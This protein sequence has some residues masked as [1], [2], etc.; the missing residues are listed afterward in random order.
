MKKC[1]STAGLALL[2]ALVMSVVGV[3]SASALE[4]LANGSA[5]TTAVKT[6][7]SGT[8]ELEDMGTGI[9]LKCEGT[10]EGT[11]GPGAA[12]TQTAATATK[13]VTLKGLCSSP[14]AK[15]VGLPWK[16]ELA[17]IEGENRD[18]ILTTTAGWEVICGGF[19]EDTC[20]GATNVKVTNE[21]SGVD[22]LFDEKSPGVNCSVGGVGM[23]LV[24]GLALVTGP[25]GTT[26]SVG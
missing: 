11:V 20:Q 14:T 3:A 23:G 15:A 26:I 13:C 5:I 24:H 9:L 1:M 8:L 19:I 21:T 10:G 25:T 16:T 17:V 7:S 12:D 2:A 22:T 6:K 18:K 4:W